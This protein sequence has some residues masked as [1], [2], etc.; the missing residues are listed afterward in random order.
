M[1]VATALT[2]D[3]AEKDCAMTSHNHKRFRILTGKH[4]GASLDLSSG[5]HSTGFHN[6]CDISITDWTFAPLRISVGDSGSVIARWT[7]TPSAADA[8]QSQGTEPRP[9]PELA[10]QH[11]FADFQPRAFGD[12]VLCIGP[13]DQAWPTDLQLL[14]STFQPSPKRMVHWAG[15]RLRGSATSVLSGAGVLSLCVI[16]SVLMMGAP[17]ASKPVDTPASVV[18]QVQQAVNQSGLP[19]LKVEAAAMPAA[20]VL[21][22]GMVTG[23]EQ[24]RSLGNALATVV[25]ALPVTQRVSLASDVAESIRSTVGLAGA[26]V[27]Y[28]GDGVFA[29]TGEAANT[30]AVRQA[31]NRVTVDLGNAVRRIDVTLEQGDKKPI[32]V[33]ILSSMNDGEISVVQTRDGVKHLVVTEPERTVS[34]NTAL[35]L[36]PPGANTNTLRRQSGANP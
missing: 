26:E 15:T 18:A 12:I 2:P 31:I 5:H 32:E 27:K 8:A 7:D 13:L 20:G 28:M 1:H 3:A 29:F 16:G 4:A 35:S 14:R 21:V 17:K 36:R 9:K 33:P 24:A 19:G 6:D 34:V 30:T 25:S 22:S 10:H 23:P 11:C